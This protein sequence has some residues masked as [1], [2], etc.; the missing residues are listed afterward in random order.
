MPLLR[1]LKKQ[2]M[3]RW[4]FL[5]IG[6][7]AVLALTTLNIYSLY[8]LRESTIEAAKDNKRNQLDEFTRQVRM[9]FISP[10]MEIRKLN[11]RHLDRSWEMTGNFPERYIQVLS[12]AMDDSLFTELYYIPSNEDACL[13]DSSPVY[14]FSS[15]LNVF[16]VATDV[17][18][19]ACDGFGL[20]ITRTQVALSEYSFNNKVTFDAHRS[21]TITLINVADRSVVG[22]LNFIIDYDYLVHTFFDRELKRH[23]GPTETSGVVVWLRD[24]MQDEILASSDE[25]YIWNREVYD[26]DFRQVFPNLLDNWILHASFLESPT[27]AASN[28]SLTRNLIVLATAVIVLFGALVFMFINAQRERELAQR[29]AGFL[30]NI[31]H[32][33]KTPLAVMQAAGENIADGRVTDGKRLRS[34]GDHIYNEAVRLKKMI[35]KLLDVAKVDSGQSV[36]E[37]APH[38]LESIAEKVYKSNKEYIKGKGFEYTFSKES[39]LP[40]VMV[41]VDQVETILNNLIENAVKYS[42]EEKY[43]AVRVFKQ[44]DSVAVSITDHGAGIPA[45]AQKLIYNKF[46]RVEDSLTAKTKGHG[47]GL[48]IVKNLVEMNGGDIRLSSKPGKGSAFTVSF[49]ALLKSGTAHHQKS[50]PDTQ[51]IKPEDLKEYV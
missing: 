3:L 38:H 41:D 13:D 50:S 7:I 46:F 30:A 51:T 23:F 39:A 2:N 33:L 29:Q 40:M 25:S 32:E 4:F 10:F 31:T 35:E 26:I 17:P 44:N 20:S 19:I 43:I 27:V 45:K 48:A 34:Y 6:I 12:E 28:A 36:V 21:M 42:F 18:K 8:A 47:L 24:W 22:H 15:D 16:T 5:G 49:P 37:Q 9:Q 11:M 14:K 1:E